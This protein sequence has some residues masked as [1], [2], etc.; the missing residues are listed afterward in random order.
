VIIRDMYIESR[1][2][3]DVGLLADGSIPTLEDAKTFLEFAQSIAK[4]VLSEIH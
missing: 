2:P 1:Y 3:S 4:I